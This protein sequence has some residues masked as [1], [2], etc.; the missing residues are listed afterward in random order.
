VTARPLFIVGAGGAGREAMDTALL[1]GLSVAAF[2]DD[3][4]SGELVHGLPVLRPQHAPTDADY[5]VA[6]A[7]PTARRR[8]AATLA[9][10]GMQAR[11]LTHPRAVLSPHARVGAGAIVQANTI[12]S[13]D[14]V[15]GAHCQV[16]YNATI[17]HD[18]V[19]AC[20]VT[21]YPG[22]H[23]AGGVRLGAGV[24]V[25]SGAVVLPGLMVGDGAVLGAGAVVTRDVAAGATVVGSPARPLVPAVRP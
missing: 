7:A 16:H 11:T 4:L 20:C 22:A 15:L 6:I 21:V 10:R 13:C 2:L 5:V 23:V 3:A 12:V 24:Q 14:A 25:G 9:A 1:L 17:G 19:L 18:A 8:L